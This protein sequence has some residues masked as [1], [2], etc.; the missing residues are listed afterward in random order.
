MSI[1]VCDTPVVN[2]EKIHDYLLSSVHPI[3]KLKARFFHALGYSQENWKEL[4]SDIEKIL[5]NGNVEKME[6]T[7]FGMKYVVSGNLNTP[8]GKTAHIITVWIIKKNE[9]ITRLITA[10]PGDKK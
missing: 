3:G 7:V 1:F 6:H 10:Y 8:S 2:K 4:A 5:L 9:S